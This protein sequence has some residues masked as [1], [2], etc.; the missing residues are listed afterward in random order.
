[1]K[2]APDLL[3]LPADRPRPA[4]QKFNGG[5]RSLQLTAEL[6][7]LAHVS[8]GEEADHVEAVQLVEQWS[9]VQIGTAPGEQGRAAPGA[10]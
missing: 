7:R 6:F 4:V 3:E 1:M 8:L 10:G 5:R 9:G 2:G